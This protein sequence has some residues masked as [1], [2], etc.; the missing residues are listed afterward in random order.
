ML[1]GVIVVA[2]EQAVAAP[3]A[4]RQLADL[5]ARVIKVERPD[6]DFARG[7]DSRMRGM[8]SHFAWL[9]RG[10]E[11]IV[12]DLKSAP[13][14]EVL[15][16]LLGRA[17]VLVQNLA[18]GAFARLGLDPPP[19]SCSITGY[20]SAGPYRTKKAYDLLIQCETGVLAV[21]G[22]EAEPAK[23]GI[24]VADIAAGMYAFSGILACLYGRERTGAGCA[25]EV[26]LLDALGEW[27]SQPVYYDL[28]GGS[29]LPRSGARHASISPYGPYSAADGQVFLGIQNAREFPLLCTQILQ[30]PDLITDPRFA[31]NQARLL[32][33]ELLG[34]IIN[35][36]TSTMPA[37]DLVAALDKAGIAC[38]QLRTPAQFA[39]HP[40]LTARDRWRS[41]DSP[42][43]PVPAMLPP[44]AFGG[45]APVMGAIPALGQHTDAIRAELGFPPGF[46]LTELSR[47]GNNV[48][49]EGPGRVIHVNSEPYGS[50]PQMLGGRLTA[51]AHSMPKQSDAPRSGAAR[52]GAVRPGR[53]QPEVAQPEVVLPVAQPGV[54]RPEAAQPGAV[55]PGAASAGAAQSG[56]APSAAAASSAPL[57]VA[58]SGGPSGQSRAGRSGG[59]R[60]GGSR[61][62]A[63]HTGNKGSS[64]GDSPQRARFGAIPPVAPGFSGRLDMAKGIA[65][66]LAFGSSVVLAP[67]SAIAEGPRNWL[68]A[69]GKTQL[70]AY[71]AE[72]MWQSGAV[73][74][75]VWITA[76]DR[77][78]LLSG[79]LEAS[80][81]VL[82]AESVGQAGRGSRAGSGGPAG[83][84]G[85]VGS[86]ESVAARFLSWLS[87]TD[88][89]WL[90]VLDDLPDV[91]DLD[92]L[93]PSGPAGRTLVTTS[94][95]PSAFGRTARV[96]PVGLYGVHEAM[97]CLSE[98]LSISPA[99]RQGSIDLIEAASREP[100]AIAQACA[101]MESSGMTCRDYREYLVR[102]RQQIGVVAGEVPS[103]AAAT[104]TLS[105]D[106]A[107]ML[108]P[109]DAV[110]LA[111]VLIALLD[112]HG[113]PGAVFGTPAVAGYLGSD[114]RRAWEVLAA[115]ERAGLISVDRHY[116]PPLVR[117]SLAV[118][119]AVL[120]AAPASWRDRA[121]LMAADALLQ[122]WPAAEPR[123]GIVSDLRANAA[124][125]QAA[126]G[127]VLVGGGCHPLLMNVGI[128]LDDAGLT[129]PAVHQWS[130]LAAAADQVPGHPDAAAIA[131]R[132]A[133]AY[134]TAGMGAEAAAWYRRVIAERLRVLMP[135]NSA[136]TDARASLGRALLQAGQV[137]DALQVLSEAAGEYERSRGPTHADTLTVVD[138][139]AAAYL[140][141][142]RVAD[143][144]GLLRRNLADRER[145]GGPRDVATTDTRARLAAA[146]LAEG[147]VK[148]ALAQ[149][150]RVLADREIVLGK[151]HPDTIEA[152]V[153][154]ATASQAAGRMPGALQAAELACSDSVRVLG[155]D[156]RDTLTRQLNL[157][158]LYYAVGRVSDAAN[159]LHEVGGRCERV[160]LVTDPLT[161]AVHQSLTNLEGEL[162]FVFPRTR[163]MTTRP[164]LSGRAWR[165]HGSAVDISES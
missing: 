19:I 143:A 37:A 127:Q 40:Q 129:G 141:M 82:D 88:R 115:L 87:E 161:V 57:G 157:A 96:L 27:M 55:L 15:T 4:T 165:S 153:S 31:T 146:L 68:G 151:A 42:V 120:A 114:V 80:A 121:A 33:D 116:D 18:P 109:G 108:Q 24:S 34:S 62:G 98:R 150:K 22:T 101:V 13:D 23:A 112:G 35:A 164:W 144:T 145:A 64:N 158:H 44:L 118:Q 128:S 119:R 136:V 113:I 163:R 74:L 21:T 102:R 61:S 100:L 59:S 11:S 47:Y 111:L 123:A 85:R 124:A 10:K 54:V 148:D 26:S 134:L 32:H 77:A 94:R 90:V 52:S 7:F 3:F 67:G 76:A 73:D 91:A 154:F 20:G 41:V 16:V 51:V 81:L 56:A 72:S 130:Q 138:D 2:V 17:D 133:A 103:A 39:A 83:G 65:D 25:F 9:N 45:R 50:W 139:I 28:L 58:P 70:A 43:G 63:K 137:E 110:R 104:W 107:E 60:S 106:H 97:A 126:A 160:L 131:N 142:G 125:L 92:G 162:P 14:V 30:R 49:P 8:S 152:R 66:T 135:G 155:A 48:R 117:M 105:L 95:V 38:A 156:H 53:V 86:A 6:G 89:S 5:G 84:A 159:V 93:W 147:E 69:S 140:D 149:S 75:L 12:L 78:S 122:V 36:V 46:P 29:P 132:L 71:V 1:D 79:Y 99:Q